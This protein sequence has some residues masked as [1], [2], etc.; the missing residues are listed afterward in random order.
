MSLKKQFEELAF[1]MGFA[2]V[3]VSMPV[4]L[5]QYKQFMQGRSDINPGLNIDPRE[6]MPSCRSVILLVWPYIPYNLSSETALPSAY[7]VASHASRRAADRLAEWIR[8]YGYQATA[9]AKIP[10]KTLAER[11]G[12][13]RYGRNGIIAVDNLGSR[14]A[15][16]CVLTDAMLP[17]DE[18]TEQ[19]TFSPE[20]ENCDACVN[21]CPVSA[22]NGD[23]LID[24]TRCLRNQPADK[25]FPLQWRTFIGGSIVGCDLCQDCCARN[26]KIV[27]T[28][29][30]T[31]VLEA[32][33]LR[34]LLEGDIT[35]VPEII[36]KNL[37]KK[38]PLQARACLVSGNLGKTSLLPLIVPLEAAESPLV[39]EAATWAVKQ[40]KRHR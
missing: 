16:Q 12:L 27:R 9:I 4:Q 21:A 24:G 22:L 31:K 28:S 40:I 32:M 17:Y 25:P 29:P 2:R 37:A 35:D 18:I 11:T 36:G 13:G 15:L 14:I 1:Q 19:H 26:H 30:S 10:L 34:R 20:C 6:T 3:H 7:Y 8:A 39:S 5:V 33:S 23:S 38:S